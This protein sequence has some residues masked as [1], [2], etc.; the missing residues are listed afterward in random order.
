MHYLSTIRSAGNQPS[1]LLDD[2]PAH[3]RAS[4]IAARARELGAA[5]DAVFTA[6]EEH[7]SALGPNLARLVYETVLTA[8]ALGLRIQESGDGGKLAPLLADTA[9][10]QRS[11]TAVHELHDLAR[12]LDSEH[13]EFDVVETVDALGSDL[14]LLLDRTEGTARVHRI[15]LREE[16]DALYKPLP[17]GEV[18]A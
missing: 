3:Q 12:L 5:A 9:L 8:L 1:G 17:A 13:D 4:R 15:D 11:T 2:A 14:Q 10:K 16:F 18:A 6:L 7:R